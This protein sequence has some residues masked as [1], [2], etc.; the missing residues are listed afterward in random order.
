M[1]NVMSVRS[2]LGIRTIF[3]I[4]G[5]ITNPAGVKRQLTGAFN[6]NLLE[7][8]AQTLLSLGTK[9]AW[10]VHG[11]DGTDELSISGLTYVIELKNGLINKF[12]LDPT[13]LGLTIHPFSKLI[14]G[15]PK[16]NAS[17]LT[18]LLSGKKSAYRDSVILNSAAA[19]YISG[20]VDNLEM[21][22]NEA[23][24]SIDKGIALSKLNE[25][26]SFSEEIK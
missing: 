24:K 12:T 17:E 8:M 10:L 21:G 11:S 13:D 9:K 14:G 1:K 5:P 19:I 18:S 3:N 15:D 2:E 4:L 20:K 6:K 25:L 22:I 7:P 23:R 16:Y 26:I